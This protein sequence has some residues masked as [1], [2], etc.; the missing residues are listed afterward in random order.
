MFS[1]HVGDEDECC[2]EQFGKYFKQSERA[3]AEEC[4]EGVIEWR[5]DDF[6][7]AVAE[8]V[9]AQSTVFFDKMFNMAKMEVCFVAAEIGKVE[10]DG[11]A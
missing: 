2:R 5:V 3:K 9:F 8:G 7:S 10:G 1:E 6:A 4:E 11:E